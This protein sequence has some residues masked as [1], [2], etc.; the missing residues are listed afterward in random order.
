MQ[1]GRGRAHLPVFVGHIPEQQQAR[2]EA[3]LRASSLVQATPKWVSENDEF[4]TE[5]HRVT[6]ENSAPIEV[7]AS[8]IDAILEHDCRSRLLQIHVPTL[9]IVARDDMLT[10]SF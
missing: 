10:P 8:R 1:Q 3:Y 6:A 7:M 2:V 5:L 4:I 9:V